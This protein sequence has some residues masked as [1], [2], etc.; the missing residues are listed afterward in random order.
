MNTWQ[1]VSTIVLKCA[2]LGMAAAAVVLGALKAL[3]PET[4]VSLLALGLLSLALVVL[5]KEA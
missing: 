3:T 4:G 1:R 2:A 5:Q